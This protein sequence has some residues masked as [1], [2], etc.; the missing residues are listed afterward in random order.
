[1]DECPVQKIPNHS[2]ISAGTEIA[3]FNELARQDRHHHKVGTEIYIVV[4]GRMIIEIDDIHYPLSVGDMVIVNPGTVHEVK[5]AG[6][7]FLCRVLTVNCKGD[8]DKYV[9]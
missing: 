6:T 3:V 4:E 9:I 8:E 1:M 2:D 5:P 7:Q